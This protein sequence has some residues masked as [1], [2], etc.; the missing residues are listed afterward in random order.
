MDFEREHESQLKGILPIIVARFATKSRSFWKDRLTP[1]RL[2]E[3]LFTTDDVRKMIAQP[4]MTTK[5]LKAW[6]KKNG[7]SQSQLARVLGVI[8]VPGGKAKAATLFLLQSDTI[9]SQ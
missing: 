7:Y 4:E 2:R 9:S 8:L 5:E 1:E 3:I 6:R